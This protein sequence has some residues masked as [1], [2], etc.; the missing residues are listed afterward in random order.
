MNPV[1]TVKNV[2]NGTMT[3][4]RIVKNQPKRSIIRFLLEGAAVLISLFLLIGGIKSHREVSFQKKLDAIP[5]KDRSRLEAFFRILMLKE[6]GGYVL[7]GSKPAA[8]TT[9]SIPQNPSLGLYQI[10]KY[11]HENMLI[12][13]GWTT[14]EKYSDLFRSE[15]F[16][17]KGQRINKDQFEVFLINKKRFKETIDINLKEFQSI[18]GNE[19]FSSDL[20]ERYLTNDQ[21]L[22][23]HVHEHHA[24]LGMLLGFGVRNSRMFHE[25]TQLRF[26][27]PNAFGRHPLKKI[28][29]PSKIFCQHSLKSVFKEKNHRKCYKF[30][31]LPYFL[32]DT[33]SEETKKLQDQY[34]KQQ[35]EI[36][37]VY[38]E[39]NFLEITLKKF[40]L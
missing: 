9:F 31:Y 12:K 11:E 35:R 32:A 36:H 6:G 28:Q 22:F 24:L 34:R 21:S 2:L 18:L 30:L 3:P 33:N 27:D 20:L 15:Q 19:I 8:F 13:E 17:L 10:L 16:V 25:T 26:E 23:H 7:F 29:L 38:S 39:G 1:A 14:W 40:C 37:Q 4:V 5:L